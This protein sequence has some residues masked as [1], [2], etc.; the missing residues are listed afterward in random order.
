MK[1]KNMTATEVRLRLAEWER[2]EMPKLQKTLDDIF[3]PYADELA[4]SI[5]AVSKKVPGNGL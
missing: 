1:D 3:E 4:K 2:I 5:E